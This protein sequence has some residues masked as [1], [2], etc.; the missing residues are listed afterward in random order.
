MSM[1]PQPNKYSTAKSNTNGG[2]SLTA[3]G[4]FDGGEEQKG[5]GS[6]PM[7]KDIRDI[8][9]DL[10]NNQLQIYALWSEEGDVHRSFIQ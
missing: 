8:I 9:E 6:P 10:Q 3:T 7:C 5:G 4:S 2:P 1:T